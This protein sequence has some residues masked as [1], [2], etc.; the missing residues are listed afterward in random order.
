MAVEVPQFHLRVTE[1][2]QQPILVAVQVVVGMVIQA[3]TA[4]QE[5]LL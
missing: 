2:M 1:Q 3:A 5:L 4:V